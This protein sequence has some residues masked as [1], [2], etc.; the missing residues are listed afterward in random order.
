MHE[1][2]KGQFVFE[3]MLDV[4]RFI[5]MAQQLGLYVIIRPSPYICA[6]WE[7]G[8]LPA[9]LLAEDGMKYRISYPPFLKHVEEYYDVLM[10]KLVPLQINHGGP[11]IVMQIENEYGYYA[12][13]NE[14]KCK[15]LQI[16]ARK[17]ETR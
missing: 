8:G 5:R 10:K 2:R 11:I 12:V 4:E 16:F 15:K 9:W 6:E 13:F 3:G 7:F 14:K 17:S 1:P